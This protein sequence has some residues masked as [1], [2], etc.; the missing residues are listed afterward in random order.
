MLFCV[1]FASLTLANNCPA[2]VYFTAKRWEI[3]QGKTLVLMWADAIG[4]VDVDLANVTATGLKQIDE[5]SRDHSGDGTQAWTPG[6]DLVAGDYVLCMSGRR[7]ADRSPKLSVSRGSLQDYA[8]RDTTH[9]NSDSDNDN[10]DDANGLAPGAAA[11]IGVG[12]TLG[13]ILLLGLVALLI[14]RGR[15]NRTKLEDREAGDRDKGKQKQKEPQ[16]NT[17]G[18]F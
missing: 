1:V 10:D 3:E 11:G 4:V 13:G 6:F 9:D 7:S 8:P 5:I 12:S 14:Y 2:G 18:V 17:H 15:Q 16:L